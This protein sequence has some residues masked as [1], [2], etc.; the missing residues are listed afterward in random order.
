MAGIL[1]SHPHKSLLTHT[2]HMFLTH[3]SLPLLLDAQ[4]H[5][6]SW[7]DY[8][9]VLISL[10]SL[11]PKCTELSWTLNESLFYNLTFCLEVQSL[12]TS[13]TRTHLI[14]PL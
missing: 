8:N 2:Y 6:F 14:S 5:P 11:I 1:Y 4:I 10:S 7:S 12:T 13:C 9:A 3:T